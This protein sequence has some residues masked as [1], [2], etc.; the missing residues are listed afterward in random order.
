MSDVS[1]LF[2]T[3]I[4]A[5]L[6][7]VEPEALLSDFSEGEWMNSAVLD[8]LCRLASAHDLTQVVGS[9]LFKLGLSRDDTHYS[10]LR[11]AQIDAVYR[12]EQL[13][14]EL[15]RISELFEKNRIRHIPLKGSVIRAY[16]PQPEMRTSCD[17][18]LL[19]EPADLERATTALC[20]VLKY[21]KGK[22]GSH[23]VAF[24]SESGV[25][26]ELHYTL[27]EDKSHP[28]MKRV[29]SR[30]WDHALP[31]HEGAYLCHLDR[32]FF[33][34]Y[35]LAHMVKH[36]E[37]G[38]C[39]IR[40]F[41]DLWILCHRAP[42]FSDEKLEQLLSE[43]GILTFA[44]YA[45]MLSEMWFSNVHPNN[46]ED[47]ALLSTM[48]DYLLRGGIYG[49]TENRVTV[50]R[51]KKSGSAAYIGS[52]LFLPLDNMKYDYPILQKHAIL[53]PFCEVHRWFRLLRGGTAR[54]IANEL[55]ING[56]LTEEETR[57]TEN[58][59]GRLGL[60]LK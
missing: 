28:K 19:I 57:T 45:N 21:Q 36:F 3:L 49:S 33:V 38:G 53:L 25:S 55:K 48:H 29:L 9:A 4:R 7:E 27:S 60:G 54:R 51:I 46:A 8:S 12:V 59:F 56:A 1:I 5:E 24:L 20:D 17:I 18:D 14:Y 32:E 23:D 34:Y 58:M 22:V 15:S 41:T 44:K 37:Y 10:F 30:V 39:G 6:L 43:G 26:L 47:E 2:L 42:R 11:R 31:E 16:Y 50:G 40:T 52:R 35:H 13:N